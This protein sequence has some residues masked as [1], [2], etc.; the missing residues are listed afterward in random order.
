MFVVG[1]PNA[2]KGGMFGGLPSLTNLDA[3]N[4]IHTTDFR[5][6]YATL[7]DK[8]LGG[9]ADALLG[10]HWDRLDFIK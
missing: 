1:G 5:Q 10:Q 9:D 3:G 6:V 4:L 7:L 8:W 2:V